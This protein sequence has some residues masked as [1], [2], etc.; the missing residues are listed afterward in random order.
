MAN[1]DE[2]DVSGSMSGS[3]IIMAKKAL[4]QLIQKLNDENNITIS[5]FNHKSE[6]VFP[7]QK[8]SDLK[9]TDYISE[10]EKIHAGGGTDILPAFKGAYNTM[11]MNICNKNN[12]RRMIIITDM[13]DDVNHILTK[14][15]EKIAE[16]NIYISIL[17][18]SNS[19]R[20]T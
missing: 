1:C 2:L 15:C 11:K 13:E 10:L 8:V 12:I 9:K 7:Y 16:E 18:I 20:S 19:F 17:E 14:F 4:I 5:K 3:R 6:Q